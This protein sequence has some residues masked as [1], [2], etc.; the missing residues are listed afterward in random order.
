MPRAIC[1]TRRFAEALTSAVAVDGNN[2]VFAQAVLA[3]AAAHSGRLDIAHS[4]AKRIRE[5]YP[6]FE[7]DA[8][9]NFER[10]HF[11][12]AFYEALVGGLRAA[13]LELGSPNAVVTATAR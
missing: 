6:Q 3:A 10:W 13:G 12:A 7:A 5:L 1:A 2:W 4:A 11:D 8:L 9:D